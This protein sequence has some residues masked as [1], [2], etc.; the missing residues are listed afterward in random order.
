MQPLAEV[1][2]WLFGWLLRNSAHAAILA[3]VIFGLERTLGRHLS[4]RWRYGLWLMVVARLLLPVAPESH[5]SLF[6]LVD[7]APA[8]VAGAALQ[9]LG[10]PTPVVVP[11]DEIPDPLADTPAWFIGALAFWA[12]GALT[13]AGLAWRNHRKM[14]LALTMTSPIL[15]AEVLDLLRQSKAVMSVKRRVAVVETAQI[16]SPAI[17]GWWRPR[18]LLPNDLL[19]RLTPDEIRFLFLHELAHVKRADLALNWVLAGIQILHWFNPMIW[20]VLRRLLAVREEVCD[21]L[22]LRRCFPGA[23]REYGL[24]L[25]RLVEECAPRRL[26]PAFAGVLDDV[27]T[28][29]QRIRC[30]R[31]FGIRDSHPWVAAGLT[32][33]VAIVGLT[34]RMAEPLL[35]R[36]GAPPKDVAL[37]SVAPPSPGKIRNL[38]ARG[39]VD[40][41]EEQYRRPDTTI[42]VVETLTAALQ[43]VAN[44][45]E[46][47]VL[48]GREQTAPGPVQPK[49]T[50]ATAASS[51]LRSQTA[52]V[53]R[54]PA[55]PERISVR[56]YP[57]PPVSQRGDVIRPPRPFEESGGA[58]GRTEAGGLAHP[59]LL[60]P[61]PRSAAIRNR[62]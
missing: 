34:E 4:P 17:T 14:K 50:A 6:N 57:L 21:D 45:A 33:A 62:G 13:L 60:V 55:G 8:G 59:S 38:A 41:K 11:A 29:R 7:L 25:L 43:K 54:R 9:V 1:A 20:L 32:V 44:D 42:Q 28:L 48:R 51:S 36:G 16:A 31:N 39:N 52:S 53:L 58:A 5:L 23:A 2:G 22:V 24:T 35:W 15:D 56:P 46:E 30:I 40:R 61:A 26:F 3:A 47:V 37:Q 18:V 27:G 49:G 10:L 19:V 12:A